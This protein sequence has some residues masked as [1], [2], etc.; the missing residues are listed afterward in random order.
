MPLCVEVV[1]QRSSFRPGEVYRANIELVN[2]DDAHL[3]TIYVL[4]ALTI[5]CRG[6]EI[7][8][9]SWI[10]SEYW[11]NNSKRGKETR[12]ITRTLFKSQP[13]QILERLVLL[14]PRGTKQF[15]V[16]CTLPNNLPPSFKGTSVRYSYELE[17]L[18]N[19]R[20]TLNDKRASLH[21]KYTQ[22]DPSLELTF[23]K[24]FSVLPLSTQGDEVPKLDVSFQS[25]NDFLLMQWSEIMDDDKTSSRSTTGSSKVASENSS[26]STATSHLVLTSGSLMDTHSVSRLSESEMSYA[27]V[28]VA[29][30]PSLTRELSCNGQMLLGNSISNQIY[31]LRFGKE[32][33]VLFSFNP[34]MATILCPGA[35]LGGVLHLSEIQTLN[36]ETRNCQSFTVMLETVE[37]VHDEWKPTKMKIREPQVIRHL[38]CEHLECTNDVLMTNFMFTIPSNAPPSFQTPLVSLRWI[39]RFEFLVGSPFSWIDSDEMGTGAEP[40][41]ETLNWELPIV[42]HPR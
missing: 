15:A 9:P 41:T 7:V 19:Y 21:K 28:P 29:R 23:K 2:Q 33:L 40:A 22:Q 38:H 4:D 10:A 37:E 30:T 16:S 5:S 14:G 6:V 35:T 3:E 24:H 26:A 36:G 17:V 27:H 12:R 13:S 32:T 25:E 1:S 18:V 20:R 11:N 39:L 8:D 34:S 42:V 31:N